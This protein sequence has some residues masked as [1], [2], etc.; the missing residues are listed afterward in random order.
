[1]IHMFQVQ[2]KVYLI[3]T[4]YVAACTGWDS[5][6]LNKLGNNLCIYY[7]YNVIETPMSASETLTDD[8][9]CVENLHIFFIYGESFVKSR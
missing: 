2:W 5:K 8:I 4:E 3:T 6:P 1:M 9:S 7:N